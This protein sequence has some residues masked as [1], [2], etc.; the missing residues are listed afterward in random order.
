MFVTQSDAA[1]RSS[2]GADSVL[3]GS[4]LINSASDTTKANVITALTT[5]PR[6]RLS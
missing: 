4:A 1:D 5:K 3:A 2:A 6:M